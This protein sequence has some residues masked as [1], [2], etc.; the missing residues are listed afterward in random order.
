MLSVRWTLLLNYMHK[1][2]ARTESTVF[3]WTYA[4]GLPSLLSISLLLDKQVLPYW[5]EFPPARA[6]WLYPGRYYCPIVTV[7]VLICT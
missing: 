4:L 5:P 1:V 7:V 2:D 3:N 6:Y